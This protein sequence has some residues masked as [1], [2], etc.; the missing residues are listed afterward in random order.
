MTVLSFK[1]PLYSQHYRRQ[2]QQPGWG[3][4]IVLISSPHRMQ[5]TL[6]APSISSMCWMSCFQLVSLRCWFS[7]I[8]QIHSHY[9]QIYNAT[10]PLLSFEIYS[11][12]PF[13]GLVAFSHRVV[14]IPGTD[15]RITYMI[16]KGGSEA[17][18]SPPTS[19]SSSP[20]CTSWP[21]SDIEVRLRL[22]DWSGN[23]VYNNVKLY[24]NRGIVSGVFI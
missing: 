1:L 5:G 11:Q 13:F 6:R 20:C 19:L 16:S 21:R 12:L 24:K 14:C 7:F 3:F 23:I 10:V 22:N 15:W 9:M 18:M 2:Q 8:E 17:L 4:D